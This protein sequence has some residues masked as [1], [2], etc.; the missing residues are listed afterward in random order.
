MS[1]TRPLADIMRPNT[2]DDVVGQ[3]ALLG[4]NGIIRRMV[5]NHKLSNLLLWGPPGCGKTTIAR[6]LANSVDMNFVPMSAVF[7]GTADIKKTMEA[8][9][10][11]ALIGRGTLL[12]IDEIH[13]FNKTQQDTLLPYLEDGTVVFIGATTENPSFNLNNALLS[14]CHIGVLEPLD[15]DD[16]LTLIDRA[17]KHLETKLP[18]NADAKKH[19]AERSDG[20]ARFLLNTVEYLVSAKFKKNLSPDEL[21]NVIQKR[22]PL[23]DKSGDEHYNMISAVHKSLRASDTDAALYWVA[24]MMTAGQDPM[25]IFRRLTRFAMEDIGLADPNAMQLALAAWQIYER[26]GSPEGD[27]AMTEL[28]IYL[29]TAPKSISAYKAQSASYAVAKRTSNL[30]PP[31]NILNAPTK[32]MKNLGYGKDYIYDPET[33]SGCSGQNC[34]PESMKRQSF[35]HPIERGFER[36]IKKRLE[37]W[38][39]VRRHA[40]QDD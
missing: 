7:S 10:T 23:S 16:L 12:F 18:L 4:E 34:F 32:M 35:Y 31:K 28:V 14:R 6:A 1:D 38:D 29:G 11:N 25:Y 3:R 21:D 22:A 17:E 40:K 5:D 33:E 39:A 15:T 24:R 19:L 27:I 9:R 13:R 20:D 2:I 8:A 36:E 37:Y 26:M 30:M